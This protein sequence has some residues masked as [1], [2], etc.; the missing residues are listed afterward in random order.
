[1]FRSSIRP[2][3]LS[4]PAHT[5]LAGSNRRQQLAAIAAVDRTIME[6]KS[7]SLLSRLDQ[8]IALMTELRT[9]DPVTI[10]AFDALKQARA[11]IERAF[12]NEQ[13]ATLRSAPERAA[14]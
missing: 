1:M 14:A 9:P 12:A 8:S 7:E 3:R 4:P 6:Q 5:Y 10:A 13:R 2:F 11:L